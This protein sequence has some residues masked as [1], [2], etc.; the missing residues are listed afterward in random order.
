[1]SA[2]GSVVVFDSANLLPDNRQLVHD[3]FTRNVT[4]GMTTL[5]SANNP[6]FS[7]QT[8]DGITGFTHLASAPTA[9][10]S[11][12]TAM[13]KIWWPTTQMAAATCLCAT[14]SPA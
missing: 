6:A 1:M 10:S 7:S 11:R 5:V 8:P 4:A 9:S 13:Q 2:D 3:V 12:F 14:R